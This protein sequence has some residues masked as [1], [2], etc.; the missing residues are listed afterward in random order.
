[1]NKIEELIKELCPDGVKF[2]EIREVCIS[3][4]KGTLKQTELQ[5]DSKYPVINS[6][7]DWYGYYNSYNNDS[8][9]IAIAS[10]GEYAGFVT[11]IDKKFWAGGLCYPYRSLNENYVLTKFIYYILKKNEHYIM[12]KLVARGSIPALNKTDIDKFKIPIP[13]IQIQIEIVGILNKF[14]ELEEQLQKEI[15]ARKQQYDYYI[16][17]LLNFKNISDLNE[18]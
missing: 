8:N 12:D 9:A 3:L 18:I 4:K 17:K 10:R 2:K 7:R 14:T 11:Y 16:N 13:P 15:E 5:K 6:G 1:M